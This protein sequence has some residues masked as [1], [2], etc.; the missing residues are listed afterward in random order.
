MPVVPEPDR[1]IGPCG[2]LPRVRRL[3]NAS[4]GYKGVRSPADGVAVG[5]PGN[6]AEPAC[7]S[8]KILISLKVRDIIALQ[9]EATL[10]D[11]LQW[12]VLQALG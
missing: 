6:W 9:V 11:R 4:F 5:F 8:T 7:R 10:R 12:C 2:R 3:W 1:A